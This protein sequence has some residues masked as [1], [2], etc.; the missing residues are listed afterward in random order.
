MEAWLGFGVWRCR[1][2]GCQQFV[3][4][5]FLQPG[6][7]AELADFLGECLGGLLVFLLAFRLQFVVLLYGNDLMTE[8]FLITQQATV[9]IQDGNR[10]IV[11]NEPGFKLSKELLPL[12]LRGVKKLDGVDWLYS[13]HG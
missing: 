1:F 2:A 12:V 6:S 5:L 11:S 9:E 8:C 7:L 3:E 10:H 4:F 13:G